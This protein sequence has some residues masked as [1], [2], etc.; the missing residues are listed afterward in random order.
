MRQERE[1]NALGLTE[2]IRSIKVRARTETRAERD[3]SSG[4]AFVF[5][6]EHTRT[7]L[8]PLPF[9]A[10]LC[11]VI[12]SEDK[13]YV[14]GALRLVPADRLNN[15]WTHGGVASIYEV[16]GTFAIL[17]SNCKRK[18]LSL[19]ASASNIEDSQADISGR[20]L[21]IRYICVR[22][23]PLKL[24][25]FWSSELSSC[26]SISWL[27]FIIFYYASPCNKICFN[28]T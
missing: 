25:D 10:P 4:G 21:Y 24:I 19:V 13:R 11:N 28:M 18:S 15:V 7:C 9:L 2:C 17:F 8:I 16:D 3:E 1:S 22:N 27:I 12:L 23:D 6:R 20:K 14:M 26:A 5:R